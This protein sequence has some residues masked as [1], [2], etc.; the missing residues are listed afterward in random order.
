MALARSLR[1]TD[2]GRPRWADIKKDP[3]ILLRGASF[4]EILTGLTPT[5]I[6]HNLLTKESY[7]LKV[8]VCSVSRSTP[9]NGVVVSILESAVAGTRK[10]L[11][12]Y[13]QNSGRMLVD[14]T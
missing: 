4:T 6:K 14:P 2:E 1:A 3:W 10:K 9:D 11:I 5:I 7:C 12:V 8:S 13:E